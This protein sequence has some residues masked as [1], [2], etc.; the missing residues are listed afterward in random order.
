MSEVYSEV[1]IVSAVRTPI[2]KFGGALKDVS[3]VDLCTHVMKAAIER[4]A[5]DA[6]NLDLYIF[7]NILKHGHGQLVPRHAAFKAGIPARWMATPWTC[8]ARR[9]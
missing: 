1:Y 5:I 6:A 7:G 3:P 4:A 2:G 9:G 8:F